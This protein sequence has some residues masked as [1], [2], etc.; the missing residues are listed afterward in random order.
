MFFDSFRVSNNIFN[1]APPLP[2]CLLHTLLHPYPTHFVS[3]FKK[4]LN[5]PSAVHIL[6]GIPLRSVQ[7]TMGCILKETGLSLPQRLPTSLLHAGVLSVLSI[8]RSWA[9]SF[10]YDFWCA[11][12]RCMQK[13]WLLCCHPLPQTVTLFSVPSSWALGEGL[14]YRCST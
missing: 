14:W 8:H 6:C 7:T 12:A 11:V 4:C 5:P 9:Y 13:A 3:S 10:N 1:H 2:P